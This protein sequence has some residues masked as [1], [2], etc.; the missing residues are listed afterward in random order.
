MVNIV[1]WLIV[2]ENTSKYLGKALSINWHVQISK[3]N[4][5]HLFTELFHKDFSPLVSIIAITSSWC[6]KLVENFELM[7]QC[8][9]LIQLRQLGTIHLTSNDCI[10]CA[11]NNYF[12]AALLLSIPKHDIKH[13]CGLQ[14]HQNLL[15]SSST[16]DQ[17][18][19]YVFITATLG[20][21]E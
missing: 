17:L 11:K 9:F 21:N 10:S 18:T 15:V 16:A 6:Y 7:F 3:V 1:L 12:Q 19:D 5:M 20:M 13:L 14:K 2:H 8:L 4:F